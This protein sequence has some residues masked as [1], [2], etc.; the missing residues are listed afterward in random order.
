MQ[1]PRRALHASVLATADLGLGSLLYAHLSVPLGALLFVAG[2]ILLGS[3]GYEAL[4][5]RQSIIGGQ[6]GHLSTE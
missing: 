3:I 2:V 1:S 4:H 6:N 5:R